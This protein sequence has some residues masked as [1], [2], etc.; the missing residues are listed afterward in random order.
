MGN[1]VLH[2]LTKKKNAWDKKDDMSGSAMP[3]LILIFVFYRDSTMLQ[4]YN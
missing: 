2:V 3:V 1:T 4:E